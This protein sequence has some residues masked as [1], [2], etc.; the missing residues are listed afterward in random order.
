[1]QVVIGERAKQARH[2]Q[3]C[4]NSRFVIRIYTFVRTYIY[5]RMY[6]LKS[7]TFDDPLTRLSW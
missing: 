3:G 1:M 4:T 7:R 6:V 2:Y 5:G